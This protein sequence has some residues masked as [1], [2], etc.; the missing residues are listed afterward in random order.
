[1]T[2][3]TRRDRMTTA[4]KREG[5]GPG[6]AKEGLPTRRQDLWAED[7]GLP[8][9]LPREKLGVGAGEGGRGAST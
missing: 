3:R 6:P 4:Q 1:M 2:T 5:V 7:W 8:F 9:F